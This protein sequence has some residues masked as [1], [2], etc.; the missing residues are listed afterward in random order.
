MPSVSC[1]S[2]PVPVWVLV[3]AS[4]ID[5][6]QNVP[7]DDGEVRWRIFQPGLFDHVLN[8]KQPPAKLALHRLDFE[9]AVS[10][11]ARSVDLHGGN[12]RG[13]YLFEN[14]HHLLEARDFRVNNVVGQQDGERLVAHQFAGGEHGVSQTESFFLAH[15]GHV[16]HVGDLANDLQQIGFA[17][18]NQHF[19]Q[20]V[21]DVEMILDGLLAAAGDHDDLVAAGGQGF[22]DAVL[23]D[24]LVH[25]RQHFLGLRF[26]GGQEASA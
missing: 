7:A 23:N 19:F 12:H 2:P 18:L 20:L 1:S 24:G 3:S 26:G 16:D 5:G 21:A 17:A 4:K 10:R 11:D 9:D 8:F 14:I 15:V 22:F 6:R 25:Q 13:L